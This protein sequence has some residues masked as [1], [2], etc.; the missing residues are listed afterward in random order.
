MKS[1][2]RDEYSNSKVSRN[3]NRVFTECG[4]GSSYEMT[5]TRIKKFQ[6]IQKSVSK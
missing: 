1:G 5:R 6:D 3:S 2:H 4:S